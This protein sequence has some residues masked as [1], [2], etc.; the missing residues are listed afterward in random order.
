MEFYST[1][2]IAIIGIAAIV[3]LVISAN[4]SVKK[5]VG[6]AAYYNLSSTFMGMTVFSLATSI[7]E[8]T[9]HLTASAHILNGTLDYQIGSAIVLG[10]NIGSDVVQQTLIM[11][12]VVLLS[13]T[14]YFR[15]YFLW[16]SMIPM[17]G[18]TVM[19]IVMGLDGSYSRL[20]GAIL[21]GTFIVYTYYL[22]IDERK[23]Y[24]KED[25]EIVSEEIAE[26]VPQNGKE[27]LIDAAIALLMLG[28]TVVDA[29]YVLK[30]TELIV[31]RTGIGG[32]LIGVVT[33][34]I[35]SAMPE[36]ITAMAGVR[37]KENGV[38]LGTLVGSNITNPLVAIGGGAL[39][40]TYAVPNP[41][42]EW[43][44]PWETVTGIILWA[45]LWFSKGKLKKGHAFYLMGLYFIYII[46]RAM[47][48]S[49]DY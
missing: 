45:I 32:S 35:A 15:R 41:L 2:V 11:G 38:S 24:K 7:P 17:I 49:V 37:H 23:H 42:I 28:V 39:L 27:V 18:T 13:G 46:L 3:V 16:K 4:I 40:S 8:I 6:I 34:G 29:G 9:S 12:L 19:C 22:Y 44:L 43:D 36:F 14:L 20:D 47:F 10:S 33:L 26:N 1:P 31:V 48:F 21:F 25:N 30:I 5:L